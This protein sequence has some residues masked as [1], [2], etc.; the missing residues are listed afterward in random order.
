MQISSRVTAPDVTQTVTLPTPTLSARVSGAITNSVKI[1]SA[2][3]VLSRGRKPPKN[4]APLE[5]VAADLKQGRK[6][7]ADEKARQ[8]CISITPTELAALDR[9]CKLSGLSRSAF[10]RAIA[11]EVSAFVVGEP[12][13][14]PGGAS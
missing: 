10:L 14:M 12:Q 8:V 5:R 1:L 11:A 4:A 13:R 3:G 7:L 2:R 6:L 9:A